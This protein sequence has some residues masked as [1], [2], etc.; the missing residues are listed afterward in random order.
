MSAANNSPTAKRRKASSQQS[1][2]KVTVEISI[3]EGS[4]DIRSTVEGVIQPNVSVNVDVPKL[5]EIRSDDNERQIARKER[6]TLS[7]LTVQEIR[8]LNRFLNAVSTLK[9]TN[10]PLFV[11]I[12]KIA[13]SSRIRSVMEFSVTCAGEATAW[14]TFNTRVHINGQTPL[15]LPRGAGGSGMT[16]TRG[17]YVLTRELFRRGRRVYIRRSSV[18]NMMIDVFGVFPEDIC[19]MD[20]EPLES[21]EDCPY[22][23]M[24]FPCAKKSSNV[25]CKLF[26]SNKL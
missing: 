25:I 10:A 4:H 7:S 8:L 13:Q 2:M 22:H 24:R 11:D 18:L 3:P 12:M 17:V 14:I 21:T 9:L 15:E 26:Q 1:K 6:L 16:D 5:E 23:G 20:Y 19:E